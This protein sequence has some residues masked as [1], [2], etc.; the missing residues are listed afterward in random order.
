MPSVTMKN[1]ESA[2]PED[3]KDLM[4]SLG[5]G[6]NEVSVMEDIMR[7]YKGSKLP[8][9]VLFITDGGIYQVD[10]IKKIFKKASKEPVFWQF[11][12]VGGSDYGILENFDTMRGRYVDN[13]NFFALDDFKAVKDSELYGRLLNEFP[14]WLQEYR[15]KTGGRI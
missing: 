5:R 12:G 3:W 9:Y 10:G 7:E 6:N 15:A 13:A 1:Y 2:V 14:I 4:Y 8:V 11:V